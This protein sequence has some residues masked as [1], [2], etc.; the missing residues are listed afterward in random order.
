M[1]R[2]GHC[3]RWGRGGDASQSFTP[4]GATRRSLVQEQARVGSTHREQVP[5]HREAERA[6]DRAPIRREDHALHRDGRCRRL[7]R[8]LGERFVVLDHRSRVK[9][10]LRCPFGVST[11]RSQWSRTW[12]RTSKMYFFPTSSS[13]F[14]P[15]K[16]QNSVPTRQISPVRRQ[17]TVGVPENEMSLFSST[18]VRWNVRSTKVCGIRGLSAVPRRGP[19]VRYRAHLIFLG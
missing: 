7:E 16:R 6:R 1:M 3:S 8:V 14:Q 4:S 18:R 12:A 15:V 9:E 13:R 17:T 5:P 2:K 19:G 10:L 11:G